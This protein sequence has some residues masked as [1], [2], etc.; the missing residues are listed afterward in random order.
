M[1]P[2]L[3]A[4]ILSWRR[5]TILAFT[6]IL[7]LCVQD[8]G[9][10][11]NKL[12]ASADPLT[13]A[14]TFFSAALSPATLDQNP[15]L[16]A[17][18]KPFLSRIVGA[19]ITTIRY[20]L[21]AMSIAIPA[22]LALG[23]LCSRAWWPMS[24][25][26]HTARTSYLE[27]SI[28]AL[29]SL[30]Y[31]AS[32]FLITFLRSIHELIWVMLFMA[33]L[34]DSPLTACIALALP[35]AGT[36][37][38][39][40]SEI[41]DEQPN[42]ASKQIR[43]AG[44]SGI[45][46]F[47]G[48]RLPQALP[49]LLT[50]TMYRLECAVRSSA[51]LGFIGVETIGLSIKQSYENNYYN[52]VWSELYLLVGTVMLFDILGSQVRKRLH[53]SAPSRTPA[54]HSLSAL[55]SS[56]PRWKFL[57]ATWYTLAAA[58]IA[59]WSFGPDL[60]QYHSHLSRWE[61]AQTFFNDLIPKPVQESGNWA[62]AQPWAIELFERSGSEA[63][64]NTLVI[65]TSALL[66]AVL[67]GYTLS[68]WASRNIATSSPYGLL[69]GKN[70][71]LLTGLWSSLG[72]LL[73][74]LFLIT[75][76]IPEYILAFLLIGMLGAHA[77]PLVIALAIH[78]FGI[79]GRLWSEVSENQDA[80]IA[81]LQ[82]LAGG[83]RSQSYLCAILPASFNR[84]ILFIFYRWE[85]CVRESTIL[86]MLSISSIGYYINTEWNFFRYDSMLFF[87]LMG[88]AIIFASDLLSIALRAQ[89]KKS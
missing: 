49:D 4:P 70:S 34:G 79:L 36:L 73:R 25:K 55:K 31:T 71:R 3:K 6:C 84:Q 85:T 50:Y 83:S 7:L 60:N 69:M 56:Q 43:L 11:F 13:A 53:R 28:K 24:P 17:D 23:F 63:L 89:L 27:F 26:T 41:I 61:R 29:L 65:A 62:D 54:H 86:G 40:F 2:K 22:G 1:P 78:N 75:R 10:D 87:I 76:S 45:Q 33:F 14:K 44:G 57:T 8:L 48:A 68:P 15:S 38:K 46:A 64:S 72:F 21:I 51:V 19:M 58:V 9:L 80:N 67:F 74:S 5:A 59:A 77:W 82:I 81:K 30:I 47:I 12:P 20:A 39:V 42:D 37:A 35:F 66:L 88:T 16:P 52:E 32:R 18:T